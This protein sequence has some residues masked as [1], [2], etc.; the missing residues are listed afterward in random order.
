MMDNLPAAF[1]RSAHADAIYG[2][3]LPIGWRETDM[4]DVR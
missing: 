3:G 2:H 1:D 4:S